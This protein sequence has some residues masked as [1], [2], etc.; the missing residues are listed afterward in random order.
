[1]YWRYSANSTLNPLKGLRCKPER[2]PSTIV[3]ALSSRVPR[4][5]TTAG[6]RNWR[7]A[8]GCGIALHSALWNRNRFEQPLHDRV[9]VDALGFGVEVGHHT[10]TQ[11]RL[12][13]R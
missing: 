2:T 9:G 12:R 8:V 11:D 5:A 1:M 7:S 4:R 6:S 10:V 13:K 3:L